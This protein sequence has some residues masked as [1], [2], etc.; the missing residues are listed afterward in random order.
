MAA[1]LLW[2]GFF[3]VLRRRT[4]LLLTCLDFLVA[5]GLLL[6]AVLPANSF[7]GPVLA[8]GPAEQK[9]V[10][11]TFDDGPYPP[12]TQELLKV[13]KE[14][15]VRATF[16]LVAANATKHPELIQQEVAAGHEIG[17]HCYQHRDWLKLSAEE[18]EEELRLGKEALQQVTGGEVRYCRPPHGFKDWQVLGNIR[19]A[20]LRTVNWSVLPR[21]WLNPGMEVIVSRVLEQ[22]HPGAIVLLHDGDSP[23]YRAPRE[24]T[25]RAT[26]EIIRKLRGQGYRFVTIRELESH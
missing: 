8:Q 21:D 24:Q 2:L 19:Q 9:I 22:V 14:E 10:A 1:L 15:Q 5:G 20:G 26:R 3:R 12:Y 4:A 16:F 13:L 17:L 11:L 7:Y 23:F 6:A 25:V 18:L